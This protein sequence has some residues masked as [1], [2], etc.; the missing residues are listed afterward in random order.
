VLDVFRTE[1]LAQDSP[2]WDHPRVTLT[3]HNSG[4]TGGVVERTDRLIV[5]NIGHYLAD[6]PL[7]NELKAE[8]VLR[9]RVER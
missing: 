7:V 4:S 3:P 9:G 2:F 6:E 8:T 1:P 5:E